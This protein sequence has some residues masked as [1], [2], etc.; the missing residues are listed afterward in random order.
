MSSAS[1]NSQSIVSRLRTTMGEN[2][3]MTLQV[4]DNTDNSHETSSVIAFREIEDGKSDPRVVLEGV[5]RGIIALED[6]GRRVMGSFTSPG[7]TFD[8][9]LDIA[10]RDIFVETTNNLNPES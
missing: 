5:C 7:F 10:R 4:L 8:E 2:A 9:L 1:E 3:I 6:L